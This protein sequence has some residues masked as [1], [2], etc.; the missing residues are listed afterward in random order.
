[1]RGGAQGSFK[2]GFPLRRAG[3]AGRPAD[4]QIRVE[5]QGRMSRYC[6]MR[7]GIPKSLWLE[8][9]VLGWHVRR[10]PALYQVWLALAFPR[11]TLALAALPG[12]RAATLA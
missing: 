3:N 9:S 10:A 6:G 1:M 11:R 12:Q 4:R 2:A 7:L 5:D 8:V